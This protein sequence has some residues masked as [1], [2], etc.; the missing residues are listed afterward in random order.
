MKLGL[1]GGEVWPSPKPGLRPVS[2]L[3]TFW[4]SPPGPGSTGGERRSGLRWEVLAFDDEF[5]L[6]GVQ[7]FALEQGGGHAVHDVVVGVE[8]GVG[9]LV[10][11][12]DELADLGVDGLGGVVGEVAGLADLAAEEDFCRLPF[13]RRSWVRA[14]DMPYSQTMARAS[15]VERSMSLPAPVVI[16]LRKIS[17]AQ[18][19]PIIMARRVSR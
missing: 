4:T 1:G 18:R 8:D 17:S 11:G 15:A 2:G 13:C 3:R 12:V 5:D 16:C 14:R 10:G 19:P 9:G 7:G 6:R